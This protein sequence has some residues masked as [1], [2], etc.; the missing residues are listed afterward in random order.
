M[1]DMFTNYQNLSDYYTPNNLSKHLT[2]PCSY[3]KLNKTEATKP[4]ELY[5]VEGQLEGYCWYYGDH[6]DLDFE[7]LGELTQDDDLGNGIYVDIVDFIKD[8]LFTFTI[9]NFRH[10]VIYQVNKNGQAINFECGCQEDPDIEF[11]DAGTAFS[12]TTYPCR[13]STPVLNICI[14]EDLSKKMVKGVYSCSL[15]VSGHGFKETL[16][17]TNDCKLL[18]K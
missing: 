13:N 12:D 9:Y 18:V 15:I 17:D 4:Y 8:K 11:I 16:F 1:I 6:I 3:T 2:T 5:N 7:L 10:E 14:D